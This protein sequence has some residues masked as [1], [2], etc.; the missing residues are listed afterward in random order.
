MLLVLLLTLRWNSFA[1]QFYS[2]LFPAASEPNMNFDNSKLT[3][4]LAFVCVLESRVPIGWV[5]NPTPRS[6]TA[7]LRCNVFKFFDSSSEF[8]LSSG[9]LQCLAWWRCRI[10]MH[11]KGKARDTSIP[12]VVVFGFVVKPVKFLSDDARVWSFMNS[13]ELVSWTSSTRAS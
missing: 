11:L 2:V 8:F 6:E 5:S 9:F 10:K 7:R 3:H 12:F 4:F 13:V 1:T